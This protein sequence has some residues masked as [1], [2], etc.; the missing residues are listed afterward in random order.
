MR[1]LVSFFLAIAVI[2]L[3]AQ[4]ADCQG[5]VVCRVASYQPEVLS[6]HGDSTTVLNRMEELKDQL[7]L[8]KLRVYM[9]LVE[10]ADSAELSLFERADGN[11]FNVSRWQGASA[12]DLREQITT[13][14]LSNRGVLCIGEQSKGLLAE[15][16]KPTKVGAVSAPVSAR[17]AFG[18][19]I[20]KYGNTYMRLTVFLFC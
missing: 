14:M 10:S 20:Q 17:A 6:F 2:A 5:P 15:R 13:R 4:R 16:I 8:S 7:P 1:K 19:T 9:F 11:T 3:V 12:G 18:H